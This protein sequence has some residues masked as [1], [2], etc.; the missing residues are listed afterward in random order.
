MEATLKHE[1]SPTLR[2]KAL[3]VAMSMAYTQGDY[4]FAEECAREALLLSRREGDV[5]AE[6]YSW[7]GMGMVEMVRGDYEVA[8]SSLMKGIDLFERCGEN[9]MATT[10]RVM[11]GTTLLAR[12]EAERAERTF[13]EGLAAARRLQ[14]PSLIYM[15]LYNLAQS[16]L[17]R[18][19]RE[20]AARL[21][22]EGIEWSERTRDRANLVYFLEALAA[23]TSLEREAER[24]AM[25]LGAAEALLEEVGARV[26]NYYDPD[27][28]LKE[29]AVAEARATLGEAAFEEAWAL[30]R[31]MSFAQA[32]E[33]ALGADAPPGHS[34]S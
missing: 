24:F 34:V 11:F 32:V 19:D 29:R 4:H 2:A 14:V 22:R 28:S 8:A 7:G 13:E 20:R 6:A 23:V 5:L 26:Y 12:G 30:G 21:L 3:A 16:A 17:A 15:M 31:E 1:L 18:G 9:Y 33:Y 10:L 25:L 27:P